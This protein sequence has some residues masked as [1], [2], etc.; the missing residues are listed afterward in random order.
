[1]P[2]DGSPR[3]PRLHGRSCTGRSH[4]KTSPCP[5]EEENEAYSATEDAQMIACETCVYWNTGDGRSGLCRRYAP[6]ATLD[7]ASVTELGPGRA[8]V[9]WPT[10]RRT[11]GCGDGS[12][13]RADEDQHSGV[14]QG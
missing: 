2:R 1:V 9:H 3:V 5:E 12:R 6:R 13:R 7:A 11:D 4:R 10:T 8:Q 14:A